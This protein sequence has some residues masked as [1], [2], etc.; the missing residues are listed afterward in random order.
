MYCCA[1]GVSRTSHTK[2]V[3]RPRRNF[4]Q[5]L[6]IVQASFCFF[7]SLLFS[8]SQPVKLVERACSIYRR[9]NFFTLLLFC[10][11]GEK[12]AGRQ[13]KFQKNEMKGIGC[14]RKSGSCNCS[15]LSQRESRPKAA[16]RDG[17]GSLVEHRRRIYLL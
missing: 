7:F 16:L 9:T 11:E 10:H 12:T 17:P 2:T 14:G 4:A 1:H 3:R 15:L 6:N 13:L 5:Y 8:F